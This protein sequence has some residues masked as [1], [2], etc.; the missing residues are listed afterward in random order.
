MHPILFCG[1]LVVLLCD[2]TAVEV[3]SAIVEYQP[4]PAMTG[5]LNSVGG[6]TL[7]NL[8]TFWAEAF[9][10]HHS[11][12]KIQ[13]EG[14]GGD[15]PASALIRRFSQIGPMAR[16]MN[17]QELA[18]F[19]K[20]WGYR[21]TQI[22]VAF[23]ALAVFVH[24]D[25]PVPALSLKQLDQIYSST[26]KRGGVD[27]TT[28]GGLGLTDEW[29]A[30]PITLFGRN[31]ASGTY[32]FVQERFLKSGSFK[33]TVQEK[34]GSTA[35]VQAVAKERGAIG[36]SA[37]SYLTAAV[38]AVPVS[39]GEQPA[40]LPTPEHVLAGTYPLSRALYLYIDKKPGVAVDPL[41]AEFIRL[42][43]SRTGQQIVVKDGFF[44]LSAA[45]VVQQRALLDP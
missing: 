34:P 19:D 13:I 33:A 8:L 30:M 35:V 4:A 42:I 9:L 37:A 10:E 20:L 17:E 39:D 41:V 31:S 45:M 36:Y 21:P 6:D 16:P 32:S 22:T 12:V 25:N 23:D 24:P 1:C 27:V 5:D 15:T 44:P 18:A 3:D 40:V 43:L 7:N 26:F 11:T 28:W 14:K 2:A 38:R 29:N